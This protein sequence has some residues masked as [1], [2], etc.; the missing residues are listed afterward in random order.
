[1]KTD[2]LLVLCITCF[3]SPFLQAQT[4]DSTWV[5]QV[6][7]RA[8]AAYGAGNH[9]E[10]ML[11]FTGALD[12]ARARYGAESQEAIILLG[13]LGDIQKLTGDFKGAEQ[14]FTALLDICKRKYRGPHEHTA[15]AL[16]QLGHTHFKLG[17]PET[18]ISL[19]TEAR[20]MFENLGMY[21]THQMAHNNT[22]LASVYQAQGFYLKAE[23]LHLE[24]LDIEKK[25][26][27]FD[28]AVYGA[29]INNLAVFYAGLQ[30]SGDALRY[31]DISLQ[32][33]EKQLGKTHAFYLLT[34]RNKGTMLADIGRYG[35]AEVILKEA[36]STAKENFDPEDPQLG[37]Y[38]RAL[39][40]LYKKTGNYSLAIQLENESRQLLKKRF[41]TTYPDYIA[42]LINEA[43]LYRAGNRLATADTLLHE[44]LQLL[45]QENRTQTASYTAALMELGKVCQASKHY[46]RARAF[47]EEGA[48]QGGAVL[49]VGHPAYH[50]LYGE[51][52]V[53]QDLL[54]N[55]PDSALLLLDMMRG[56]VLT[57]YGD[58][59]QRTIGLESQY[60]IAWTLKGDAPR[61]LQHFRAAFA[62][63]QHNMAENFS[64]LTNSEREK[65]AGLFEN[66][67]AAFLST[68]RA[69]PN[70]ESIRA[71]LYE[72]TLFQKELLASYDRQLLAGWQQQADSSF[73]A[74]VK[75]R[76]MI[77]RQWTLPAKERLDLPELEA[78]QTEMEKT[79]A[80][81]SGLAADINVFKQVGWQQL[82][83]AL[84]PGDAALEWLSLPPK[85][86]GA[87]SP[88][89]AALVLRPSQRA[90]QLVLLPEVARVD[91]L[92]A[93]KGVRGLQYAT[94]TYSGD[95]LYRALWQPMETALQGVKRIFYAPSGALH[96][97]DFEAIQTP[98]GALLLDKY[99]LVRVTNTARLL[100]P[101]FG[102]TLAGVHTALLAGG[103]DYES[104]TAEIAAVEPAVPGAG[105]LA[106]R[107]GAGL[108]RE[109][110]PLPNTLPEVQHLAVLLQ[111]K[112]VQVTALT[113]S[114]GSET[115][116]K[117]HCSGA[118][119]IL[120]IATHGFFFEKNT[121]AP[122]SLGLVTA[123]NPM[124][125]SGLILAG[126]NPAWRG[127]P[128][129]ATDDG[130]LT[131]DEI[132]LL[133]L[134]NTALAVLSACETGLGDVHDDE[135]IYGL[136]RAFRLAG[137]QNLVMSLWRV[138][139]VQTREFMEAFYAVL[140]ENG[141]I[142]A[143]F[144]QA[145]QAI[146]KKYG[147]PYYWA[148][149]VLLE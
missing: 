103:L 140:L 10:T 15:R 148:G 132:S 42:G 129:D 8:S 36:L 86:E 94:R 127:Q 46:C 59:H 111:Q 119:E 81:K 26:P 78:R 22:M 7:A 49:G 3:F 98:G 69:F 25:L 60:G 136:Q 125:R 120:H 48:R 128:A 73:S 97:L 92:F 4:Y 12:S 45:E 39:A 102:K 91:S 105:G 100:D 29:F 17:Q 83:Q 99:Q 107:G 115:A 21:Y 144:R 13:Y 145:R 66:Y 9:Q 95:A 24:A 139:D 84:E 114:K 6:D 75:V 53:Q 122:G 104:A 101:G 34:L 64:F 28:E 121:A 147:N 137:V 96:L 23:Q 130:I 72:L 135:G 141:D 117:A 32:L 133:P 38:L 31:Y 5:D 88:C 51:A 20:Q 37:N 71:F 11:I 138:P 44:A 16:G 76:Q 47:I 106:W 90:P 56:P 85:Q 146:R 149:F 65:F 54:D 123:E 80:V 55:R 110:T 63:M 61:A 124:F 1:M 50:E 134:R 57:A 112:K 74:Y 41:G 108:V 40:A 43:A 68:A 109:W 131:A 82:Q 67:R 33:K 14:T 143:A 70:D 118:P 35:E 52:L 19:M 113:G 87:G 93:S 62:A 30:Q 77:A 2:I 79:M 89:Y 27:N 116:V 126:A 18:A 58:R 142:R